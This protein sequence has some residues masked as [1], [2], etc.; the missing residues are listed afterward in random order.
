MILDYLILQSPSGH[1]FST[2]DTMSHVMGMQTN[3][4]IRVRTTN[5]NS[6]NENENEKKST[7]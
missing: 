3:N 4:M 2:F 1:I 6:K 7:C 5:W